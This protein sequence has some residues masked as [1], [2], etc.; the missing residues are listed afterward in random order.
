MAADAA[1]EAVYSALYTGSC[2]AL[3]ASVRSK[4]CLVHRIDNLSANLTANDRGRVCM[5]PSAGG[6]W[7]GGG[8][9]PT[10]RSG[11]SW[12]VEEAESFPMIYGTIKK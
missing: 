10:L 9:I 1:H 6:G 8:R 7:L 11:I 12:L 5:V 4:G 2:A 3:G